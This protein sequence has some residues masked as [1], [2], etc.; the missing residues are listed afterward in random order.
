MQNITLNIQSGAWQIIPG[1]LKI[2]SLYLFN[3]I[4]LEKLYAGLH[5]NS[6]LGAIC[7]SDFQLCMA[8]VYEE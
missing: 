3:F 7:K 2:I 5:I 4:K 6:M 1:V 8:A